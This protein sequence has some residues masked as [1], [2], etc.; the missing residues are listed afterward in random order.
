[1]KIDLD[2][3]IY[4]LILMIVK[5]PFKRYIRIKECWFNEQKFQFEISTCNYSGVKY[6]QVL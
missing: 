1:M 5:V 3:V 6:F 2:S 4:L